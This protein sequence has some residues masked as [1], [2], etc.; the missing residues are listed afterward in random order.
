MSTVTI[1]N[2]PVHSESIITYPYGI[3]DPDYSCG[4]HTGL[5]FAPYGATPT[6]P[7]LYSVVSGE[8]VQVVQPASGAL[9][10]QVLILSDTN[11]YWRYCHMVE[12]SVQVQVGDIVTTVSPIGQMGDTGNVSGIHLHLERATTYSWTCGTFL[13]P[14]EFLQIP[15]EIGTIVEYQEPVPPTPV[16]E[17][18]EK[19]FPWVIYANKIRTRNNLTR[20]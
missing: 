20:F 9:G 14:A 10:V 12:G 1:P 4:W 3:T 6:N 7:M 19:R 16:G 11:E 2:S 18:K 15:N 17:L 8:V 13:N 5:D